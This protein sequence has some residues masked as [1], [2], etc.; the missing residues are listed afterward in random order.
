M[1]SLKNAT[2]IDPK[3]T[4]IPYFNRLKNAF[5]FLCLYIENIRLK[6]PV[7]MSVVDYILKVKYKR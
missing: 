5:E 3:S 1:L 2:I 7:T 4:G 6:F